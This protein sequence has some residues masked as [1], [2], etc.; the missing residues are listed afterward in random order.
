MN[1]C[2]NEI[3]MLKSTGH[4]QQAFQVGKKLKSEQ[5]L[6]L[7]C[8]EIK[9]NVDYGNIVRLT[10]STEPPCRPMLYVQPGQ[11]R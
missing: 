9:F 2:N 1:Q 7:R 11:C 4:L 3:G 5:N 6:Y 8:L 10:P